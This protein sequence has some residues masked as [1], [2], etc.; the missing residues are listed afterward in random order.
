MKTDAEIRTEGF[1]VLLAK[2]GLVETERF[3]SLLKEEVFDYAKWR[4]TLYAGMTMEQISAAAKRHWNEKYGAAL[5]LLET[6]PNHE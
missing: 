6:T 2:L 3:I 5:H 1:E 4:R